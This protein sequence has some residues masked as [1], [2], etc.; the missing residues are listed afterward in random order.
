[1]TIVGLVDHSMAPDI[2]GVLSQALNQAIASC[3][4]SNRV[5]TNTKVRFQHN[6]IASK[7]IIIITLH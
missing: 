7:V 6:K 1:M 3:T 2:F 4:T 5:D